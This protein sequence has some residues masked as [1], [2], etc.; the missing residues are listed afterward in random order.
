[1]QKHNNSGTAPAVLLLLG[2]LLSIFPPTLFLGIVLLMAGVII[3]ILR[4][5]INLASSGEK[6]DS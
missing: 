5:L 6:D 1:M 4:F 3:F 2:I